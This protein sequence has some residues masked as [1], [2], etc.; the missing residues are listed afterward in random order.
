MKRSEKKTEKDRDEGHDLKFRVKDY[1]ESNVEKS[2][3]QGASLVATFLL[4]INN[5]VKF[6]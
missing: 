4:V 3:I 2:D 1:M 6:G 5:N